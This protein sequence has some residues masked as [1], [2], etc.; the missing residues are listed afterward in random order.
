[1]KRRETA[2]FI[3]KCSAAVKPSEPL[4]VQVRTTSLKGTFRTRI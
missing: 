4:D 1:M 3:F 2:L